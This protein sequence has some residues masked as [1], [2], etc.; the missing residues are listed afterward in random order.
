MEWDNVKVTTGAPGKIVAHDDY[1]AWGMVV[2]G[3]SGNVG[4][5]DARFKFTGKE[6]DIETGFFDFGPRPYNPLIGRFVN[7]D[8][9]ADSYGSLSPY[10][11]VGNNP[12]GF[13]DPTGMDSVYFQDQANRPLDNGTPGTSYTAN[14]FVV[15]NGEVTGVYLDAGSTYPNSVS[16][17]DN[18]AAANTVAE[19]EHKFNNE[20]GHSLG[21]K[22]G[23]NLVNEKGKRVV[24]GTKPNGASKE[25]TDVN[26]HVGGRNTGDAD[27]RRSAGCLTVDPSKAGEFFGHFDWSKKQGN[28]G[29]SSG[30]VFVIRGAAVPL[31]ISRME[32]L[33]LRRK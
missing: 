2:E 16:Q 10:V 32:P 4:N 14:I 30:S 12:M 9:H 11:Y 5:A 24:P 19:G 13:V 20:H 17:T 29:T 25:M 1:D 7:P 22:K 15:Q 31:P 8:P 27:S 28:A 33:P 3:R 18:S 26:V 23:L 21:T 6:L